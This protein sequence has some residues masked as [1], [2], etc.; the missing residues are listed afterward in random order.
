MNLPPEAQ[1]EKNEIVE[2]FDPYWRWPG[3]YE[4]YFNLGPEADGLTVEY[5]PPEP[6]IL[7]DPEEPPEANYPAG[8]SPPTTARESDAWTLDYHAGKVI[9]PAS[10]DRIGLGK[11]YSEPISRP[12][13]RIRSNPLEISLGS[14][15]KLSDDLYC[16][17]CGMPLDPEGKCENPCCEMYGQVVNEEMNRQYRE[18]MD[19]PGQE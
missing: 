16:P 4:V 17:S 8:V 9:E 3:C 19:L 7:Q 18:Q 6:I 2:S 12:F 11:P 10:G 14:H 13:C 5:T 15:F 1:E